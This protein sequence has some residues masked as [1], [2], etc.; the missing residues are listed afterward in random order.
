MS[1]SATQGGH[2]NVHFV[3]IVL[4]AAHTQMMMMMMNKGVNLAANLGGRRGRS[5]TLGWGDQWVH[6]ERWA[7]PVPRKKMIFFSLEMAYFGEF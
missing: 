7:R 6:G 2:K 5:R 4:D 3:I 1:A